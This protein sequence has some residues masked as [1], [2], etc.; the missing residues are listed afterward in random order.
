MKTMLLAIMLFFSTANIFSQEEYK[1]LLTEGKT[2]KV[3]T[4]NTNPIDNEEVET[5]IKLS[6]DTIIGGY[7]CKILVHTNKDSSW[8]SVLLEND[9]IIYRYDESTR[10]FLPLMDFNLHEGDQVGDWGYVLSEDRVEVNNVAYRRLA[11]GYE[12]DTP[13]AYWVEGIGASKDCWITLF[14]THIGEYSYIHECCE[15]GKCIFSAADFSKDGTSGIATPQ[16]VSPNDNILYD[17]QG[18]IRSSLMKGDIFIQNGKKYV[19]RK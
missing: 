5:C 14:E 9:K 12:E 16:M 18:R 8:I 10:A 19:K 7:I 3:V 17:L 4:T 6:G 15:N 11:I 13:I 1:S 2:W